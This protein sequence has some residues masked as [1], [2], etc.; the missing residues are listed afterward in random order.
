MSK[1]IIISDRKGIDDYDTDLSEQSS[2][3]DAKPNY[4]LNKLL[5]AGSYDA[6]F[7]DHQEQDLEKRLESL[8]TAEV[9]LVWHIDK[10]FIPQQVREL[11]ERYMQNGIKSINAAITDISKKR[12]DRLCRALGLPAI[13]LDKTGE[14]KGRVIVKSDYNSFESHM[15]YRTYGCLGE[16]PQVFLE[17]NLAVIQKFLQSAPVVGGCYQMDRYIFVGEMVVFRTMYSRDPIIKGRNSLRQYAIPVNYL[18]LLGIPPG[19]SLNNLGISLKQLTEEE[20]G[21]LKMVESVKNAIGLDVGSIDTIKN[22]S[23]G[24]RYI[25]DVNKTAYERRLPQQFVKLLAANL[26]NL[27]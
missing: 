21:D 1:F 7:V 9:T 3:W 18:N 23:D 10:T 25:I 22:Q 8:V 5:L 6:S 13:Q 15:G 26:P 11:S 19:S 12:V 4:L 20:L 27:T 2:L 17:D 24:Q 14:Y 16:V